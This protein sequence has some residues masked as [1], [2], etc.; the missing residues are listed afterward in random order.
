MDYS[1]SKINPDLLVRYWRWKG[2][3]DGFIRIRNEYGMDIMIR[4]TP[5]GE[6]ITLG[7]LIQLPGYLNL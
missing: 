5:Y 7:S 6:F 3:P 4:D 2:K 1:D